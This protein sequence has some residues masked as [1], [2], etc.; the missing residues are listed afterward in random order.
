MEISGILYEKFTLTTFTAFRDVVKQVMK[1]FHFDISQQE[2]LP[3]DPKTWRGP[4]ENFLKV[5][6]RQKHGTFFKD[7]KAVNTMIIIII[8]SDD[9]FL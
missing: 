5:I 8:R 3:G 7:L 4:L 9:S 6:I 1:L 2:N